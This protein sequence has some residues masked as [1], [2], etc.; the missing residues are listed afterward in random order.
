MG[1][2]LSFF[3]ADD[4]LEPLEFADSKDYLLLKLH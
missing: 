3:E 1:R 4:F 2:V